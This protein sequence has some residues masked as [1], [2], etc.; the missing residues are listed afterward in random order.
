VNDNR[1][2]SVEVI[3]K[4]TWNE[5]RFLDYDFL[6]CDVAWVGRG[7]VPKPQSTASQ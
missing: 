7:E 2:S 6:V 5:L 3:S 4:Q 1:T